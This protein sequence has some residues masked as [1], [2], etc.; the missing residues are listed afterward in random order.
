MA[1]E[2][3]IAVLVTT[4]AP[5]LWLSPLMTRVGEA[6]CRVTAAVS[7]GRRGRQYSRYARIDRQLHLS[8]TVEAAITGAAAV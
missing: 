3:G 5:R 2:S 4:C 8:E 6:A 1:W 7:A